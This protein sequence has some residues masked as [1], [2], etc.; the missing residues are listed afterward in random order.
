MSPPPP[1]FASEKLIAEQTAGSNF[2]FFFLPLNLLG[3]NLIF[4][5]FRC[6]G[7]DDGDD[8]DNNDD[9]DDARINNIFKKKKKKKKKL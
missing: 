3:L 4:T 1:P 9:D 8:D 6:D 2:D 7:D 5:F